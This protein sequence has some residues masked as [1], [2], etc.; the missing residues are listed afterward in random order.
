[1]TLFCDLK[2]YTRRHIEHMVELGIINFR[3]ERK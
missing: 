2:D 1:V 3:G